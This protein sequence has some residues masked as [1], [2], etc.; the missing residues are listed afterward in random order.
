MLKN[1]KLRAAYGDLQTEGKLTRPP[2]GFD[3]DT[4]HADYI[5]HKSFIVWNEAALNRNDRRRSAHRAGDFRDAYALVHGCAGCR[6]WNPE[7]LQMKTRGYEQKSL[8]SYAEIASTLMSIRQASGASSTGAC[9]ALAKIGATSRPS[10]YSRHIGMASASW[11][12]TSGGVT[13]AAMT[14]A[15]TIT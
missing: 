15:P 10:S 2:K 13:M 3:A 5:R 8:L 1:R 6:N 9:V 11:L 14:K 12:T 7:Y 4:P